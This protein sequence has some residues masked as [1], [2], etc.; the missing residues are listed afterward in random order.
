[1]SDIDFPKPYLKKTLNKLYREVGVM[2]LKSFVWDGAAMLC[3]P[4][5]FA[6]NFPLFDETSERGLSEGRTGSV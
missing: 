6:R 5:L 4:P 3:V 2:P 1:M